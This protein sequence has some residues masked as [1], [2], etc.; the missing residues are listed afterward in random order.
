MANVIWDYLMCQC[1]QCTGRL[2]HGLQCLG[3]YGQEE[4]HYHM[5][6]YVLLLLLLLHCI[7]P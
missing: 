2:C 3:N 4:D 7:I 5:G 1:R 6:T